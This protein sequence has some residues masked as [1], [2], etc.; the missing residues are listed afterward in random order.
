MP[1]SNVDVPV[2]QFLKMGLVALV[3]L[4]FGPYMLIRPYI[5]P[6]KV[7]FE[8]LQRVDGPATVDIE[9]RRSRRSTSSH[10]VIIINGQKYHYLD[11]APGA[12]DLME[13]IRPGERISIWTDA[14]N[15]WVW[16]IERNGELIVTYDEIQ[17]V[18]IANRSLDPVFG[19]G[20]IIVGVVIA[21]R[22]YVV[23]QPYW[24]TEP[25][26]RAKAVSTK[27]KKK[28]RPRPKLEPLDE[29]VT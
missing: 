16:Q 17:K 27:P 9:V 12:D 25:K 22:L 5:D 15:N 10:P 21:W 7:P 24:M 6:V 26:P 11:S 19:V 18:V 8:S 23:S 4:I 28:K 13:T 20:S 3:F 29:D 2:G 14:K 1:S